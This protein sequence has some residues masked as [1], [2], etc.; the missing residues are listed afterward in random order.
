MQMLLRKF[1]CARLLVA[2]LKIS[3]CFT[4]GTCPKGKALSE[5]VAVW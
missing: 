1:A 3:G 4:A 5:E 2:V